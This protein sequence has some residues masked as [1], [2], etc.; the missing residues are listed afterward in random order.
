MTLAENKMEEIEKGRR[1]FT[2]II[3]RLMVH[4]SWFLSISHKEYHGA[5][6]HTHCITL[7]D[8]K[9]GIDVYLLILSHLGDMH[10]ATKD[11]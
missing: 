4:G 2:I 1:K 7:S 3:V 8:I 10:L 5:Y 9:K 11:S 6:T